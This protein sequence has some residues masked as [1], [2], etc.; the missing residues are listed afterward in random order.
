MKEYNMNV[1][2]DKIFELEPNEVFVMGTNLSGKHGAGAALYAK[3]HFGA[4]YGQPVGL[5]GQSYGIPTRDEY[6]ETLPLDKIE[7]YVNEF[8]IF[9]QMHPEMKFL[10]TEIGCGRANYKPDS[11]ANM[12]RAASKLDNIYLPLSFWDILNKKEVSPEN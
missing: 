8:A 7:I 3:T 10:V 2:P 9:A 11:I 6:I 12:F 1:A 5:Q 4:I